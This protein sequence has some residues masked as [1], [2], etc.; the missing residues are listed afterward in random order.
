MPVLA[1]AKCV[2]KGK[3][4]KR[5]IK[6]VSREKVKRF[7]KKRNFSG[8]NKLSVWDLK[9][10]PRQAARQVNAAQQRRDKAAVRQSGWEKPPARG[11][12]DGQQRLVWS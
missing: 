3:Y 6:S 1:A 8:Q 2:H 4:N 10:L 5:K 9:N 12:A 11:L 7:S